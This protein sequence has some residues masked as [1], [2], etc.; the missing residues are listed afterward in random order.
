MESQYKNIE[1]LN[2]LNNLFG[3]LFATDERVRKIGIFKVRKILYKQ[4]ELLLQNSE[5]CVPG[6]LQNNSRGMAEL[7]KELLKYELVEVVVF[8]LCG[9][10]MGS[11]LEFIAQLCRFRIL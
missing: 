2:A 1:K 3:Y 11:L 10:F 9:Y 5:D 8:L 6:D 4:M 7:G